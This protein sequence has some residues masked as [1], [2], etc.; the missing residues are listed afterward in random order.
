[1]LTPFSS[2]LFQV[3]HTQALK[4]VNN[5]VL[6]CTTDEMLAAFGESFSAIDL[7]TLLKS[8]TSNEVLSQVVW[9]IENISMD[10]L[11]P[12]RGDLIE[13]GV[14]GALLEVS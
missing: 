9:I 12:H 5:V 13:A 11:G 8:T 10:L 2:W 4:V 7:V 3:L 1:M 6:H 14:L